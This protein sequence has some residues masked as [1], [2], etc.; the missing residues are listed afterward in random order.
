MLDKLEVRINKEGEKEYNFPITNL[1][2]GLTEYVW[3][4]SITEA[5]KKL[6]D[7]VVFG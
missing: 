2:S 6:R 1:L 3:A 7:N 4:K 5:H